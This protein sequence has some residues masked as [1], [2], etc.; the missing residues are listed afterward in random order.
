MES[1]LKTPSAR[2]M[3]YYD[4]AT[5]LAM[6]SACRFPMGSVVALGA[7]IIS[8]GTNVIKTHPVQ[9]RYG[10]HVVSIHAEYSAILHAR[11]DLTGAT[12]Y[13][14]RYK[15]L[16]SKPCASCALLMAEAG[17]KDMVYHDGKSVVKCRLTG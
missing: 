9:K 11:C 1:D 16:I 4:L 14:A 13:V 17:I 8:V 15:D 12:L 7:R 3:R 6:N 10:S 2:D 5:M